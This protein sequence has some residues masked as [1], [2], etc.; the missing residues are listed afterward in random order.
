[1][2]TALGP[3]HEARPLEGLLRAPGSQGAEGRPTPLLLPR[4]RATALSK[5]SYQIQTVPSASPHPTTSTTSELGK[6]N[7]KL[8]SL[9]MTA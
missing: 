7:Q 9:A 4:N 5:G 8:P 2:L 1:M 6:R 3:T